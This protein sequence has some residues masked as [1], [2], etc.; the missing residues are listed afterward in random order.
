MTD[1]ELTR[2]L[3][4]LMGWPQAQRLGETTATNETRYYIHPRDGVLIGPAWQL[5][6]WEGKPCY[7]RSWRPW[8]PLH[9]MNDAW[10][11]VERMKE[12]GWIYEL[13]TYEGGHRMAFA[14]LGEREP[15]FGVASTP[16][17]A[18]CLAALPKEGG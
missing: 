10:M 11:V 9:D 16:A 2:Q 18:I 17:R 4:A 5:G 1:I 15:R 3:A 12:K 14:R 6:E 7:D 13:G 8:R